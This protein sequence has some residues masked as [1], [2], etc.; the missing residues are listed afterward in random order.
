MRAASS[1]SVAKRPILAV[2]RGWSPFIGLLLAYEVMRDLASFVGLPP[3]NLGSLDRALFDGQQP[4]ILLQAAIGRFA[5]ADL[6]EDLAS[7]VYAAHFLLPV[8]VGVW[9]WRRDRHTFTVFGLALLI[10]CG[11]AFGTY[12][13]APTIPPWLADPAS[14]Q[15]L[16]AVAVQRSRLPDALVWLYSHHD[17]NLYAA[18]PSLHAGFP[19]VAAMIAVRR[20]RRV[21]GLL[22]LW[23]V[24]VWVV[25][26]YLGEHYVVDVVGGI[27]YAAI[28]VAIASVVANRM[29]GRRTWQ[30]HSL[31]SRGGGSPNS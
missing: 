21:A 8:V 20:S 29:R 5:D 25:V 27:A 12:V 4:T 13:L 16:V 17:Y 11:L 23:A 6:I 24:V 10:L 22:A 31:G 14:V 9:L 3:H 30:S 19:A 15:H 7:L 26:V 28:A 2:V 18:F 1:G